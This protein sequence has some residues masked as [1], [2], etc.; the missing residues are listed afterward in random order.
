MLGE[1]EYLLL[2]AAARLGDEAYG[3]AIRQE[4]ED[5]TG[6]ACSIGA[7]YTTLDRLEHKRLIKTWMGDPT[8]E[9][10]GR[11]KRMVAVTPKGV[12]GGDIVLRRGQASE[13]RRGVGEVMSGAGWWLADAA[14]QLLE[15][16]ERDAVRGDLI[17][18]GSSGWRALREILGLVARRQ[19]AFWMDWRPWLAMVVIVLPIGLMLSHVSRW[20]ADGNAVYIAVYTRL[21]DWAHLGYPG[22]RRDVAM[23]I[24][25]G[26]APR[27]LRVWLVV[28]HRLSARI[29]VASHALGHR[30]A[31]CARRP[32]GDLRDVN[33]SPCQQ[34]DVCLAFL[35]RGIPPI[36]SSAPDRG[37]RTV[38]DAQS[39]SRGSAAVNGALGR[40][41]AG[42]ADARHRSAA[43][44]ID[45][46]RPGC[47]SVR[48]R[49]GRLRGHCRRSAATVADVARDDLADGIP[50]R[51]RDLESR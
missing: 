30:H 32:A 28:D 9:R 16:R 40:R 13:P 41:R 2:T 35:W 21:W 42:S 45:D 1:F 34:R 36:D 48:H 6:S 43:R 3:A 46:P 47:L 38:G 51:L 5:A 4:I 12:A 10:G 27:P 50:R 49:P 14:S 15:P 24:G 8:P 39:Q 19:G 23:L 26:H 37:A 44:G 31:V 17:E 7:L 25:S 22:W 20:L 33:G 18:S 11:P 29:G